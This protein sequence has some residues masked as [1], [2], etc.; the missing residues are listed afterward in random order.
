MTI[1]DSYAVQQLWAEQRVQ[2]GARVIGYTIGLTSRALLALA[3]AAVTTG[4]FAEEWGP[5]R[6]VRII[7]PIIG[8][9]NGVLA[10]LVA[11]SR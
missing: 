4:A 11:T 3:A 10:R 7:A 1:E 8:S 5:T 9:T 6:P 2:A